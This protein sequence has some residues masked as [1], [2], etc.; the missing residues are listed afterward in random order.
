MKGALLLK[1]MNNLQFIII[2]FLRNV[3]QIFLN[4]SN[5]QTSYNNMKSIGWGHR[6]LIYCLS[7]SY[8]VLYDHTIFS[9]SIYKL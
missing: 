4:A 8:D 9:I 3:L 7:S 5:R 2:C 1:R 6:N